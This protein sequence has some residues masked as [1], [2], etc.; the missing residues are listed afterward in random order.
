LND[1]ADRAAAIVCVSNETANETQRYLGRNVGR[2]LKVIPE[3]VSDEFFTRAPENVFTKT[4]SLRERRL[5]FFLCAG[6]FNPRKNLA[7]VVAAFERIADRVPHHLVLTGASGWDAEQ[8]LAAVQSSTVRERIHLP[9]HVTVDEL[10]GLYQTATAFVFVSL[11]EGFGLPILEAMASCCPVIT[12]NLSSMPEVAGDAALLVSPR[13]EAEI[14]DAMEYFGTND[15]ACSSFS[16]RGR[17]RALKF[18]WR[19]CAIAVAE[20]YREIAAGETPRITRNTRT[21]DSCVG[22]V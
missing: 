2:R 21:A 17:L 20:V 8:I 13:S 10:R 6:S 14:A 5:P 18:R 22:A 19:D 9:G 4:R 7:R 11:M 12:S 3:G 16:N 1:A 15:R